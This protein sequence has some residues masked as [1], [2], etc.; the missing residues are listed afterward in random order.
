MATS[1]P[2]K[3]GVLLLAALFAGSASA[4]Y[5]FSRLALAA[6][7]LLVASAAAGQQLDRYTSPLPGSSFVFDRS[8][9]GSYGSRA[10]VD[11]LN[12][13]VEFKLGGASLIAYESPN[14][15]LVA[16]PNGGFVGSAAP[17]G[18]MVVT[19][20]PPMD[21]AL[22]LTVGKTW[23][24]QHKATF[25]SQGRE[26]SFERTSTVEAFED[27]TVPAGTFKAYRI[28]SVDSAGAVEVN[29]LVPELG[30]YARRSIERTDRHP[31]GPGRVELVLKSHAIRMP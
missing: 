6:L 26:A 7:P 21:F 31:Q 25:H 5:T 4:M 30:I 15:V 2:M 16:H 10:G 3:H 19:W 20:D 24:Q 18:K 11:S 23:S 22:P 13:V 8:E 28:R 1:D 29:W 14:N 27:V 9:S 12:K 17:D